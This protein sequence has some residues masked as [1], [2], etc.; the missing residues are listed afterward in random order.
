MDLLKLKYNQDVKQLTNVLNRQIK[1]LKMQRNP[2]L[3]VEIDK[4]I[5]NYK[6][7]V[8]QLYK[9]MLNDINNTTNKNIPPQKKALLVGINYTNTPYQLYGCINDVNNMKQ[10]L[11]K[12]YGYLEQNVV[13]LTDV[14]KN[15]LELLPTNANIISQLTTL[16]KNAKSGD[17][18]VFVYSGHGSSVSDK[19][20][21]ETSGY[22]SVLVP[23]D[24]L[25]NNSKLIIDDQI[26]Q[27]INTNLKPGVQ[28]FALLD[29]CNSG[30]SFD[31]RYN[32]L[33]SDS[34][35]NT[36]INMKQSL[37]PSKVVM[38][39]GCTDSQT[40]ADAQF[41][42]ASGNMVSGGAL[43]YTFMNTLQ[44]NKYAISYSNLLQGIRRSLK[45]NGYTQVP[46]LSS[47][48]SLN[49]LTNFSI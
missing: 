13:M 18:L 49:L 5:L 15:N 26:K 41:K 2:N 27:L 16:L 45:Q 30:T 33:N 24:S 1:K 10:L 3:R 7:A 9:K 21:D 48:Q 46:Q 35:N 12:Q 39:S 8:S 34:G 38:L 40:S 29:C 23:L 32:Y 28:L 42:D 25:T 43:T 6:M 19:N 31:L 36:S 47:G 11:V 14:V 37:T 17:Q 22:D 4:L 44:T 20:G